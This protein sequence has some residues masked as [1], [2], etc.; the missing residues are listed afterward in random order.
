MLTASFLVTA[1]SGIDLLIPSASAQPAGPQSSG[2]SI[3]FKY[4]Y[5]QQYDGTTNSWTYVGSADLRPVEG[6]YE[7]HGTGHYEEL[8]IVPPSEP[9]TSPHRSTASGDAELTVNAQYSIDN[10]VTGG[11]DTSM[12]N[13]STS[14]IELIYFGDDIPWQ[15]SPSV[16]GDKCITSTSGSYDVGGDCHFYGIDFEAGGTF[17]KA[18]E[19]GPDTTKCTITITPLDRTFEISG[20]VKGI[21]PGNGTRPLSGSKVVLHRLDSLTYLKPLSDLKPS[22]FKETHTS[23]DRDASYNFTLTNSEFYGS[24]Q[25]RLTVM[26]VVSVLWYPGDP[27]FAIANGE[28]KNGRFVPVY[29][30]LCIDDAP[31]TDCEKWR[32]RSDGTYEAEVNFEYGNAKK[33][34]Q[35]MQLLGAENWKGGNATLQV[36]SNSAY[37]YYNAYIAAKYFESLSISTPFEPLMIKSHELASTSCPGSGAFFISEA[38]ETGNYPSFGDLGAYLPKV[39][40]TG[41]GIYFCD[42]DSSTYV[43]DNPVNGV[44]HEMGHYLHYDM[45]WARDSFSQPGHGGYANNNSTNGGLREGFG[46]FIGML[47]AESQGLQNP[48]LYPVED[49][50]VNVETDIKIWGPGI[51]EEFAI[52]GILWDLHDGGIETNRGFIGANG[53]LLPSSRV[54]AA[55]DDKVTLDAKTI[56]DTINANEPLTLVDIYNSFNGLVPTADLDMIFVNHGAFADIV[57]RNLVHDSRNETISQTGET[58]NRMYRAKVLPDLP[59]SYLVSDKDMMFN[60]TLSHV[61]PFE[62]YDFS[63]VLAMN[64]GVPTYFEMPPEYY[65]SKAILTPLSEDGEPLPGSVEIDSADYWSY[66]G[67][68]PPEN[69][70]FKRISAS[71]DSGTSD[72]ATAIQYIQNVSDLLDRVSVEYN[73]GNTTGA[74][75]LAIA[76]YIDNFERVEADLDQRNATE[77]KEQ[78]EQSLRVELVGLIRDGADSQAVDGKIADIKSKLDEVIVIV[79]EFP[80]GVLG[81]ISVLIG[82][83]SILGRTKLFKR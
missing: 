49:T 34:G 58:P 14:V 7:G 57:Q 30:A 76:A 25:S 75:E 17:Q 72:T 77:L 51:D 21:V 67:S 39:Q 9:C 24:S 15:E 5:F 6:G 23:E 52:A 81:A 61:Q 55:F 73:A 69:S 56:I 27:E 59:G 47:I 20:T 19:D 36:L 26:V 54:L 70:V 68:S 33:L 28:E 82:V 74:E 4:E 2:W 48:H 44:W 83:V 46:E 60:V 79:P 1:L 22:F 31:G 12:Y 13:S 37:M 64:A 29:Q 35:S 32:I 43:P 66:I 18:D 63:Y 40:A 45:Y 71:G 41:S 80:I 65:P 11:P 42:K 78:I 10:S 38:K 8:I 53:T 62:Y 3:S 50:N 16:Q